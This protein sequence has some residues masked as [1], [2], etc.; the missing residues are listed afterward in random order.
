MNTFLLPRPGPLTQHIF[1]HFARRCLGQFAKLDGCGAL[2]VGQM[3]TTEGDDLLLTRLLLWLEGDKGFGPLSPRLVRYSD[4]CTFQ[5]GW[6]PDDGLLHFDSGDVLATRDDDIFGTIAQFNI[7][8]GMHDTY[9]ARMKPASL[10]CI[11]RSCIIFVITFSD[12][13]ASHENL[14][15]R[16]AV[17][18]HIVHNRINNTCSLRRNIT[19]AL[20]RQQTRLFLAGATV[21]FALPFTDGIGSVRLCESIDMHRANIE[22]LEL[23]KQGG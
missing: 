20:P 5:H 13:V 23:S 3:L 4:Y 11:L 6:M 8:V 2:E 18:R 22:R 16:L 1:L 19:L 17:P 7:V 12:V 15:H 14:S 21:P 9:I 10:K